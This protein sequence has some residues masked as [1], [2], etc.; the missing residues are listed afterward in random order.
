MA[1]WS[2]SEI[3]VT[4]ASNVYSYIDAALTVA[5]KAGATAT[6]IQ[7]DYDS[8]LGIPTTIYY[9]PASGSI[10]LPIGDLC[11][12]LV[13]MGAVGYDNYV[14]ISDNVDGTVV[15]VYFSLEAGEYGTM[16][17][18]G[19]LPPPRLYWI[20]QNKTFPFAF[21]PSASGVSGSVAL[22][23]GGTN[24]S[25]Q[26][27]GAGYPV[28]VNVDFDPTK[29]YQLQFAA[30]PVWDADVIPSTPSCAPVCVLTWSTGLMDAYTTGFV[31][32][33]WMFELTEVRRETTE[34][35]ELIPAGTAW[36]TG[37]VQDT[38]K[39]Y[40]LSITVTARD[41]PADYANY[42]DALTSSDDVEVYCSELPQLA[43][44]QT[45]ANTTLKAKVT[46]KSNK[47]ALANADRTLSFDLDILS[48]REF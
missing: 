40:K 13:E 9:F 1:T 24:I 45:L 4:G 31:K 19:L 20:H 43:N 44:A 7:V 29:H 3:E 5:L 32:T 14:K 41:I 17:S 10:T 8:R 33:S 35:M 36:W 39:N 6:F 23:E 34:T 16:P 2:N 11:R 12:A 25:T 46:T 38:R 37:L 48:F 30:T 21:C 27:G 42:F 26:Y 47:R 22:F 15:N 28:V 18:Q